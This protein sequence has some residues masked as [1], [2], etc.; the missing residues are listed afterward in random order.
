V[1]RV[2]LAQQE[3]A[4]LRAVEAEK[5]RKER[6]AKERERKNAVARQSK[7]AGGGDGNRLGGGGGGGGSGTARGGYNPLQPW[8]S[9]T[10]GYRPQRRTVNRGGG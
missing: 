6:A 3:L 1:L 7:S 2:R 8:N 10:G 9:G 4:H 5:A